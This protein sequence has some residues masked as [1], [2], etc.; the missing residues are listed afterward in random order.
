VEVVNQMRPRFFI[1]LVLL[2]FAFA[3][4]SLF[5]QGTSQGTCKPPCPNPCTPPCPSPST[6]GGGIAFEISPYAGYIWNANNNGV[7]SFFNTNIWGVR[8]GVY[9]IG[10]FEIGGNWSWNPRFQPKPENTTAAF[11]GDLGFPQAQVRSNLWELEF[12]YNFG[13]RG[14][15]GHTVKPYLVAGAGGITTS[16]NNGNAFVLNNRFI[17]VPGVS[18][19]LLQAAQAN[20]TLQSFVPGANLTNG[21]VV[22]A[23]PTA[24]GSSIV[25][26]PTGTIVSTSTPTGTIASTPTG[27]IVTTGAP[28]S[29]VVVANDVLRDQTFFTFSY[30]GGLKVQRLWGPLGFFGDIRGRTIPNLFNGHGTNILE[31]SAGLNFAWGEK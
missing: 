31:L 17:D 16:L 11:A 7:G 26:T 8:G 20:G 1:F 6:G 23:N 19:D 14:L 4:S 28:G 21:A 30:G 29:T 15:F 10:G 27:T 25:S 3:S 9:A 13:S 22:V 12:T 18:P 24:T 2:V 5:A